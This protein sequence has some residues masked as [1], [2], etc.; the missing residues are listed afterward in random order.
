MI[1]SDAHALAAEFALSRQARS[2]VKRS[3]WRISM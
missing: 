2:G 3:A 1:G